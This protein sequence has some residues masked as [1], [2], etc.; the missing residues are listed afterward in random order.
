[1]PEDCTKTKLDKYF[2]LNE[3]RSG[4]KNLDAVGKSAISVLNRGRVLAPQPHL[5]TQTSAEYLPRVRSSVDFEF[6]VRPNS[7]R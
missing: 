1:M 5:P 3:V 7:N 2:W 6:E 4:L